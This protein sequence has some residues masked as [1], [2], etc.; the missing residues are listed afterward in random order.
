M[1]LP[2]EMSLK[3]YANRLAFSR[4]WIYICETIVELGRFIDYTFQGQYRI[5]VLISV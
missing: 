3:A 2:G 5:K 1:I 4:Y